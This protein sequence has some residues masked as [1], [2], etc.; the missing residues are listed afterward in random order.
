MDLDR[1]EAALDELLRVAGVVYTE[2][3]D[4]RVARL[5]EVQP[6]FPQYHRIGHKRQA[7]VRALTADRALA[8]RCYA[9]ALRALLADEDP[10]SPRH[11]VEA[12]A[13][14]VGGRRLAVDLGALREGGS[15]AEREAA[16]RALH[17]L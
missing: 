15:E 2:E 11:L 9:A 8:E 3:A 7:A 13:R 14:T 10:N 16:A 12:L 4:P 5:A 17:W 1:Q 6:L